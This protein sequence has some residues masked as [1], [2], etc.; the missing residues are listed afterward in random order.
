MQGERHHERSQGHT[1]VVLKPF[2]LGVARDGRCSAL[3]K[4]SERNDLN[5]IFLPPEVS[6]D[7]LSAIDEFA[8]L[9]S[10]LTP[11]N[12]SGVSDMNDWS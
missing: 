5:G 12:C 10:F 7:V 6:G 4:W 8:A 2:S 3:A 11:A 9:R 1:S